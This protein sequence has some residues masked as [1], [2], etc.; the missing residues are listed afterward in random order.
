MIMYRYMDRKSIDEASKEAEN[1]ALEYNPSERAQFIRTTLNKLTQWLNED[2]PEDEIRK[3]APDFVEQYPELFKKIIQR[4]DLTPIQ[5]ML[6][7]LDKMALG[8]LSQHQA[9]IHI[10]Q[11]LVD[12]F[13]TPQL[14]SP[15]K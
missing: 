12:T 1:R 15:K 14:A 5:T 11:K 4:Q 9:S 7:L 13:V 2:V 6:Q 3:R 10:G 8:H